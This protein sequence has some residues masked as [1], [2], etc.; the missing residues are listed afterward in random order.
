MLGFFFSEQH[1]LTSLDLCF[2]I[3][4]CVWNHLHICSLSSHSFQQQ[5]KNDLTSTRSTLFLSSSVTFSSSW[6]EIEVLITQTEQCTVWWSHPVTLLPSSQR[7]GERANFQGTSTCYFCITWLVVNCFRT[8]ILH[9][10]CELIINN[11]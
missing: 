1:F 9:Y 7:N 3:S 8:Q 5:N 11:I 10:T 2:L 6:E 4:R